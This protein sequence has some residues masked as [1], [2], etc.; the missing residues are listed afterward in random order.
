MSNPF[1]SPALRRLLQA[2]L[3]FTALS[4]S[5]G[6]ALPIDM[7]LLDY[8]RG[9]PVSITA[10]GSQM[11]ITEHEENGNSLVW[12]IPAFNPV[13]IVPAIETRL[14]FDYTFFRAPDESDIFHFHLLSFSGRILEGLGLSLTQ[15]HSDTARFE[16]SSLAGRSAIGMQFEMTRDDFVEDGGLHSFLTISNLRVE[17]ISVPEPDTFGLMLTGIAV[18]AVLKRARPKVERVNAR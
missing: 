8:V 18:L 13:L 7:N 3:L 4:P 16:L 9:M 14:A 5:V 1:F 15:S 11:T 6:S 2:A 17:S 10:D 12:T